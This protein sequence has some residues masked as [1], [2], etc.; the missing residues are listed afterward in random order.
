MQCLGGNG[1]VNGLWLSF[2][3]AHDPRLTSALQSIQWVASC[4]THVCTPSARARRRSGACSSGV[5]S[6]SSWERTRARSR[7]NR[8]ERCSLDLRMLECTSYFEHVKYRLA[9]HCYT[10][11]CESSHEFIGRHIAEVPLILH[12]L[13]EHELVRLLLFLADLAQSRRRAG[14]RPRALDL[15][16]ALPRA[17]SVCL[18]ICAVRALFALLEDE[19][20]V[21]S[22]NEP[23]VR[24]VQRA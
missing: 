4:A 9:Q 22:A 23:E 17:R 3:L 24:C 14:S 11:K 13:V 20:C 19:H 2:A 15:T 16:D 7:S 5:S 8:A 12:R 1:Y 6:M 18:V 10:I 21:L